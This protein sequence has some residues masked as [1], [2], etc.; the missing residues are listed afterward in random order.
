[1]NPLERNAAE[2]AHGVLANVGG[3][4]RQS[5]DQVAVHAV[6]LGMIGLTGHGDAVS[7]RDVRHAAPAGC[8]GADAGIAH[9][10]W[11]GK[12]RE[13]RVQRRKDAI[14]GH[15]LQNLFCLV[16]TLPYLLEKTLSAERN[17]AALRTGTDDRIFG[18]DD[19]IILFYGRRRCFQQL[20]RA[21]AD[22]QKQL[23]HNFSPYCQNCRAVRCR[24]G[25]PH[26]PRR[27]SITLFPD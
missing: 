6:D 7:D 11:L 4:C 16:R 26:F 19:D 14:D 23:L 2:G 20:D 9:R 5:G 8:H 24:C 15:F 1:M 18:F 10:H 22:H 17:Q 25:Q 21:V 13:R 12:T 27:C 3:V